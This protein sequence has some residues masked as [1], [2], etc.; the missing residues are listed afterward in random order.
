MDSPIWTKV[1]CNVDAIIKL[2][3]QGKLDLT[4]RNSQYFND[5]VLHYWAGGAKFLKSA[6]AHDIS[7]QED[8]LRVDDF[9]NLPLGYFA[10][11]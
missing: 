7:Y 2:I 8:S 6:M 11:T 1:G 3:N 10:F 9:T 4:Q 5:T